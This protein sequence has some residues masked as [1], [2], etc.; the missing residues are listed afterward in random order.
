MTWT[1]RTLGERLAEAEEMARSGAG[2]NTHRALVEDIEV[3]IGFEPLSQ[4]D[5]D[6]PVAGEYR[7]LVRFW[8]VFEYGDD[9]TAYRER[10]AEEVEVYRHDAGWVP[11]DTAPMRIASRIRTGIAQWCEAHWVDLRG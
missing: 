5:A 4:E 6:Y 10:P 3:G 9:P 8:R 7:A 2:S 1:P 11:L